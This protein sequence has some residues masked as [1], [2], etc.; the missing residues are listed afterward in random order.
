MLHIIIINN[1]PA[2]EGFGEREKNKYIFELE[3]NIFKSI[4]FAVD[5]FLENLRSKFIIGLDNRI[6]KTNRS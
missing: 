4:L 3:W 1:T 2:F 6:E 5:K